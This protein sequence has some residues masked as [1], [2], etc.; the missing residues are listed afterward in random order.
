MSEELDLPPVTKIDPMPSVE[1]VHAKYET[2]LKGLEAQKERH[3]TILQEVKAKLIQ[4][5]VQPENTLLELADASRRFLDA[6]EIYELNLLLINSYLTNYLS[7][8]D[9]P[10]EVQ[11]YKEVAE[12]NTAKLQKENDR[13]RK[14]C[15]RL[16]YELQEAQTEI[17]KY[18]ETPSEPEPEEYVDVPAEPE[19]EK[20]PNYTD[21]KTEREHGFP[22]EEELKQLK[23]EIND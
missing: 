4:V 2:G 22:T 11:A 17:E 13:L 18:V 15:N 20:P 3:F 12:K 23:G 6:S 1:Q 7:D 21:E 9:V 8:L 10:S 14:D 5:S 16:F 19:P